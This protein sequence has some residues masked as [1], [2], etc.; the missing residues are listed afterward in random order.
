MTVSLAEVTC[1]IGKTCVKDT[2]T[3]GTFINSTCNRGICI[4]DACSTRVAYI[5][6]AST[7]DTSIGNS[8]VS[9]PDAVKRSRIH[10]QYF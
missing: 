5:K 6:G 7:E 8:C 9:A 3:K 10:W 2:S 4:K 1:S